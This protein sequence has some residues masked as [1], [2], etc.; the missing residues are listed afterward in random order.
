MGKKKYGLYLLES[1]KCCIHYLQNRAIGKWQENDKTI[2]KLHKEMKC[3]SHL[4]KRGINVGNISIRKR[5]VQ[6]NAKQISIFTE[7]GTNL[8]HE[9]H[10]LW[11]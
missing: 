8:I 7:T 4:S 11:K 5:M 6:Y 9:Q 3:A 10:A 2:R 1:L